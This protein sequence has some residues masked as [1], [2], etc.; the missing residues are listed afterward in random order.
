MPRSPLALPLL[1]SACTHQYL[2]IPGA[3]LVDGS[4]NYTYAD[5]Y[6]GPTEPT[7]T[8]SA[9]STALETGASATI[10]VDFSLVTEFAV[11]ELATLDTVGA[12]DFSQHW[13]FDLSE[14]E[15]AAGVAELEIHALDARPDRDWCQR[16]G[17]GEGACFL[18]ADLGVSTMGLMAAGG[19]TTTVPA[20]LPLSLDPLD[21]GA[22]TC[23]AYDLEDCCGGAGG[24]EALQCAWDPSCPCPDGTEQIG[25]DADGY[26]ICD[27][28]G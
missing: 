25:T 4:P 11:T 1:L 8:L 19:D 21:E 20:W 28:P 3:V 5:I 15:R 24:V 13:R 10:R 17:R 7:W 22:G 12:T 27:C 2:A 16:D 26:R 9:G 23:D 14:E 6:A 18:Q